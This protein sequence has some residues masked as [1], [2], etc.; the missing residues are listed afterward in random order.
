MLLHDFRAQVADA[1]I[2]VGKRADLNS[3]IRGRPSLEDVAEPR[4][5]APPPLQ[6]DVAP[7][8]DVRLDRFDNF[9]IHADKRGRCRL[10]NKGYTQMATLKCKGL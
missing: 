1:L 4:Q 5:A 7:S 10:C 9:P 2:K 3:S 8:V 6:R